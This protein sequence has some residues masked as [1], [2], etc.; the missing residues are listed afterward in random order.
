M[1]FYL[2][3]RRFPTPLGT[4]LLPFA[5]FPLMAMMVWFIAFLHW[6][7][8]DLFLALNPLRSDVLDFVMVLATQLGHGVTFVVL[9]VGALWIRLR[10]CLMLATGFLVSGLGVQWGKRMWWS[11]LDRP[12]SYF[13]GLEIPIQWVDGIRPHGMHTFPSGHTATAF[14]M[15]ALLALMSTRPRNRMLLGIVACGVAY[16]RVYLAQH[17]AVD[18]VVGALWGLVAALLAAWIFYLPWD[19]VPALEGRLN[20]RL[21]WRRPDQH[22]TIDS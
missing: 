9:T 19:N 13:E 6:G 1:F 7:R 21:Q 2:V 15:L 20:R 3:H 14:A 11:D 5:V 22:Q 10:W 18:V 17:F 16:S 12:R 4:L 8:D